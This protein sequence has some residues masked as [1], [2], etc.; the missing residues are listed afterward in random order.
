MMVFK[1]KKKKIRI[2]MLNIEITKEL[3]GID[4]V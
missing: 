2:R 3:S 4:K 1:R